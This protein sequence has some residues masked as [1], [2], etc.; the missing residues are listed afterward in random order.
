MLLAIGAVAPT[1]VWVALSPDWP[2][3]AAPFGWW[4]VA[5]VTSL[6]VWPI[7]YFA[8]WRIASGVS[9]VSRQITQR[10]VVGSAVAVAI[11]TLL[12]VNPF[13][14][15]L[16]DSA[17]GF[18]ARS[19]ARVVLCVLLEMPWHVAAWL[20]VPAAARTQKPPLGL[21]LLAIVVA[22]VLPAAYVRDYAAKQTEALQA[23]LARNQLLSAGSLSAALVEVGSPWLIDEESVRAWRDR[24]AANVARLLDRVQTPLPADASNADRLQRA[25]ELAMLRFWPQAREV[26]GPLA[27]QY[28]DAAMLMGVIWQDERDFVESDRYYRARTGLA[29]QRPG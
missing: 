7:C 1:A 13:A 8:A 24:T 6:L 28:V 3:V 27:R 16:E 14:L 10:A 19:V 18:A 12:A 15:W 25:Q 21:V 4:H 9:E 17:D 20:A 11:V 5:L 22:A 2:W 29:G 26:I 23:D